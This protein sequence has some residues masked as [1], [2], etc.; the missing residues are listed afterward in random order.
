MLACVAQISD[1]P[2]LRGETAQESAF[3]LQSFV[4]NDLLFLTVGT[5]LDARPFEFVAIYAR[6]EEKRF[7]ALVFFIGSCGTTC[8]KLGARVGHLIPGLG[9][10][11][12]SLLDPRVGSFR[13]GKTAF[14]V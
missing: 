10:Y 9:K 5:G 8:L 7:C 6:D 2:G 11:A 14:R 1:R 3:M 4:P 12:K 13:P